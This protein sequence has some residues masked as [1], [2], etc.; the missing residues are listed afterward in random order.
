MRACGS[1]VATA[2]HSTADQR[3]LEEALRLVGVAH[4]Q[5][6]GLLVVVE[7][8]L[9]VLAADT[10]LLVTAERRVRGVGVVA[11]GPHPAGLDVPA[12]PVGGV[13]VA[14]PHP[15]AEA[16]EGVVCDRDGVV[17]VLERGHGDDGTEDLLLEQSHLVVAGEDRRGHIETTVEVAAQIGPLTAGDQLGAFGFPDLDVGQDLLQLI[18]GGLRTDHRLGVQ[19]VAL[20]HG[21][22]ADGGQ[23][24]EL[25]VD[26]CLDQRPRRAGAHLTLVQGEHGEPFQGF[27]LEVIGSC[28]HIGEEDVGALAAQLEGHRDEVLAGVLHDQPARGG[29]TGEGDLG[30]PVARSQRLTALDT[31]PVDHVHHARGQQITDQRH[32]VEHRNRGLL[33]GF[34]DDGVAC[35]QRRSQLPHRHQDREV[36]GDDLTDHAEWLVEVVGDGVLVDLRERA[37]LGPQHAGEVPEVVDRQR[38]VGVQ[39]LADRLAVVPRL[40]QS[41][42]FEV[43]LDAV[44][45]LVEDDG[46][47]SRRGLAPCRRGGVRGVQR[48]LDVGLGGAGHLAEHLAGDRR[49]VLEVAALGG[50][51]PL[52][53]DVVVVAGLE[54]HQSAVGARTCINSHGNL[55]HRTP[56]CVGHH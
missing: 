33:S 45:D 8:H 16:V 37:F 46:A 32:Q 41:D 51:D 30:D 18:V 40:G 7:H 11:V 19:R 42:R 24:Q 20:T 23:F 12:G 54:R 38:D 13:A 14:A 43:L 5:V 50:G 29:L 10:G 36:P 15:G 26:V 22:G 25:V 2:S 31:E 34:E 47:R 35:G 48:L 44:G 53:A 9:V 3:A 21:L 56:R 39:R 28:Q 4:Q 1:D 17:V 52:A 27:V 55:L 49:R 6:L